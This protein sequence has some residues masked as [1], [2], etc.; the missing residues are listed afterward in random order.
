VSDGVFRNDDGAYQIGHVPL[1]PTD[2]IRDVM[3]WGLLNGKVR[4]F[5][6]ANGASWAVLVPVVEVEM[7]RGDFTGTPYNV[8]IVGAEALFSKP[9][10][11]PP[12]VPQEVL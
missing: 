3:G 10:L 5:R 8:A 6:P 4:V 9:T 11:T 1:Y 12:V 7:T 2:E